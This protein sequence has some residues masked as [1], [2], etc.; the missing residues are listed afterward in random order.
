MKP[1]SVLV[2]ED[3][4][5]LRE[6][7]GSA[8]ESRGFLVHTAGTAADAK[9]VFQRNDPDGVIIDVDLGLG[10]NGFDLADVLRRLTPGVPILFLTNLPDPRCADRDASEMPSGIAY[11][12]KPAVSDIDALVAALD[13]ALRGAVDTQLRHDRDPDRP[14]GNLTRKQIAVLRLLAEGRSNAQIAQARGTTVKAVEDTIHRICM[15]LGLDEPC[16]GNIRVRAARRYL[17]T[18]SGHYE[19]P[20][21]ASECQ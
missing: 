13:A 5:L 14:L 21:S 6:L 12:C 7:I 4:S 20:Q 3:E 2:V 1:R 19:H 10:P 15:A 16:P 9:R 17:L 8:L 11:L 18:I